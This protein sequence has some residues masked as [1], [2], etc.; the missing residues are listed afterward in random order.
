M[1]KAKALRLMIAAMASVLLVPGVAAPAQQ[2]SDKSILP[3]IKL[4]RG[5]ASMP[6]ERP[7]IPTLH[8][9]SVDYGILPEF[10]LVLACTK[11]PEPTTENLVLDGLYS[12]GFDVVNSWALGR[13][14]GE[15]MAHGLSIKG[16]SKDRLVWVNGFPTGHKPGTPSYIDISLYS[17][18]STSPSLVLAQEIRNLAAKINPS[19]CRR[20]KVERNANGIESARTYDDL[21]FMTRYLVGKAQLEASKSGTFKVH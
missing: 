7:C 20:V 5:G 19:S 10:R 9:S 21:E 15:T 16:V 18:P 11:P 2:A 12:A 13:A 4:C 14:V 8:S 3:E 6:V 1:G 17:R